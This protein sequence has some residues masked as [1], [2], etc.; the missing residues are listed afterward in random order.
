[1]FSG[2]LRD[3][4]ATI[5]GGI[6]ALYMCSRTWSIQVDAL[7]DFRID[8]GEIS[9]QGSFPLRQEVHG[10]YDPLRGPGDFS[11]R[12]VFAAVMEAI[13]PTWQVEPVEEAT[14][15]LLREQPGPRPRREFNEVVAAID[16]WECRRD[17]DGGGKPR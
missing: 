7:F 16:R 11:D 5:P 1:L 4:R 9:R 2:C 8:Y 3:I 12:E 17:D 13:R 6:I 10:G 14:L 15:A